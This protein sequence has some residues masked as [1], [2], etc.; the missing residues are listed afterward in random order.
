MVIPFTVTPLERMALRAAA[1]TTRA[2]ERPLYTNLVNELERLD[3]T[4]TDVILDYYNLE[5]I[6][7]FSSLSPRLKGVAS[8]YFA[9]KFKAKELAIKTKNHNVEC[10]I[11]P[12]DEYSLDFQNAI[13]S[14]TIF[15]PNIKVFDSINDEM[16]PAKITFKNLRP[17]LNPR[18]F[19]SLGRNME[20]VLNKVRIMEFVFNRLDGNM[21][22][23]ILQHCANIDTLII[24]HS[25]AVF[26]YGVSWFKTTFNQLKNLHWDDGVSTDC[27]EFKIF[28][29]K[30]PQ[31]E[32]L[33]VSRNL[34][35]ALDVIKSSDLMLNRLI[36]DVNWVNNKKMRQNFGNIIVKLNDLQGIR[37]TE[38]HLKCGS[39]G[40]FI[41]NGKSLAD[42]K[43]LTALTMGCEYHP[44]VALIKNLRE[45]H[46]KRFPA[47]ID[48]TR[49]LTSLEKLHVKEGEL[50]AILPFIRN[51]PNLKKII[52]DRV[53]SE[54]DLEIKDLINL[55]MQCIG[56]GPVK[57]HLGEWAYLKLK[58]YSAQP[59]IINIQRV[60]S[61]EFGF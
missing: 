24:T 53:T 22:D 19:G 23:G 28:M 5:C 55:R 21:L 10:S 49:Q 26:D 29:R 15:G 12:K 48:A 47:G 57:L 36:V 27:E 20:N 45:L 7:N 6:H 61:I 52:I 35:V 3:T 18:P 50:C 1:V 51:N 60:E 4:C 39:C 2:D 41:A 13:Q 33:K 54:F 9:R 37:F 8:D 46:V 56:G 34:E 16:R 58:L 44:D 31:I 25:K 38:L 59:V 40:F 30:N 42:L 14:V 32:N 17:T 11:S 43:G